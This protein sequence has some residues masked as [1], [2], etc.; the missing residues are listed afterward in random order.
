MQDA[1]NPVQLPMQAL[2][3]F[4][5]AGTAKHV[6]DTSGSH[7]GKDL[8]QQNNTRGESPLLVG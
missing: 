8:W 4:V 5:G 3:S 1:G 7:G 6:G 2:A